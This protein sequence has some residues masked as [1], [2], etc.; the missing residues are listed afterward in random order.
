MKLTID[1]DNKTVKVE[2]NVNCYEFIDMMSHLF[3]PEVRNYTLIT[4]EVPKIC[5]TGSYS[6]P[7]DTFTNTTASEPIIPPLYY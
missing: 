5:N 1:T 7:L 2:G 4:S 6:I 3:G